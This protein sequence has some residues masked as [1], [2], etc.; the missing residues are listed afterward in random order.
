MYRARRRRLLLLSGH[1]AGPAVVGVGLVVG[2][3]AVMLAAC[4]GTSSTSVP[5]PTGSSP[6]VT[7][8][9]SGALTAYRGMWA[10]L[11]SAAR[12]SNFQSAQLS[13][14]ATG[15]ALTLFVQGL[16][17]YQ[18]HDIVTRGEPVLTPRSPR[19]HRTRSRPEPR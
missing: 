2:L 3:C 5:P 15:E 12:T 1:G 13:Q 19:S 16:A 6:S 4:S 18:L 14:Y 11:V 10:D 8:P 17:R 9:S 7:T